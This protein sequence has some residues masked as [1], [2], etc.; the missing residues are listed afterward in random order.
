M[1][2]VFFYL[3]DVDL[4]VLDEE[5]GVSVFLAL[6]NVRVRGHASLRQFYAGHRHFVV[7]LCKRLLLLE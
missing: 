4:A 3:F 7:F 6:L 2:Y 1:S 5:D